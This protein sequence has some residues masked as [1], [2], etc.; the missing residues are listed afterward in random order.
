MILESSQYCPI[1]IAFLIHS[2]VCI[3]VKNNLHSTVCIMQ[4]SI[5]N[6]NYFNCLLVIRMI[7]WVNMAMMKLHSNNYCSCTH[8]DGT[9]CVL[10]WGVIHDGREP[11]NGNKFK[12]QFPPLNFS[13]F[14]GQLTCSA[15]LSSGTFYFMSAH[16]FDN[17]I[18][19][20]Q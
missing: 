19:C 4:Y 17:E 11:K 3:N 2:T 5:I 7:S 16:L 15:Q 12:G 18:Y 10:K 9:G 8:I 1:A 14:F 20:F 13:D 6:Y